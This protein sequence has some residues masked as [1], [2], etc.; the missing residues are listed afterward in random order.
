MTLT[1]ALAQIAQLNSDLTTARAT[2]AG[3]PAAVEAAVSA[4]TAPITADLGKA[5]ADLAAAEALIAEHPSAITNAVTVATAPL[6]AKITTLEAS[7][8]T[9]GE[10]AVAKMASIGQPPVAVKGNP[11][12]EKVS[13]A[14]LTALER[15][16]AR[17]NAK[18]PAAK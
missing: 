6:T 14:G 5:K 9:V 7:A 13:T 12:P 4:A 8:K 17:N 18:F 2:I 1:E 11:V 3:Q 16:E 10:L 15:I